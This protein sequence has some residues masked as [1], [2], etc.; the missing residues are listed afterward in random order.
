LNAELITAAAVGGERRQDLRAV[1]LLSGPDERVTLL[2]DF[3]ESGTKAANPA[4]QRSLLG[5]I[6]LALPPP[7]HRTNLLRFAPSRRTRNLS[8]CPAS[9]PK[10]RLRATLFASN[11]VSAPF[12]PAC[13]RMCP[14][15]VSGW[16]VTM[17]SLGPTS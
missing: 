16:R 4:H 17:W 8:S 2:P 13:N 3:I 15:R 14:A 6:L 1:C 12:P 10:P 5:S 9:F 7:S 11:L